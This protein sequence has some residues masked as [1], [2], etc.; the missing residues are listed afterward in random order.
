[1]I[2]SDRFSQVEQKFFADAD[3]TRIHTNDLALGPSSDRER[4]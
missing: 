2:D 4:L 1:M 3:A